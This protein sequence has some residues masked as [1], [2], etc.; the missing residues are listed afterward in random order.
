MQ[1]LSSSDCPHYTCPADEDKCYRV[2]FTYSN[3]ELAGFIALFVTCCI[4]SAGGIGAASLTLSVYTILL[5]FLPPDA[6]HLSRITTLATALAST[7]TLAIKNFKNLLSH[8]G[9]NSE[10]KSIKRHFDFRLAA[11]MI[12]L[13]LAGAELGLIFNEFFCQF[14]IDSLLIILVGFSFNVVKKR[15]QEKRNPDEEIS[16][17]RAVQLEDQ[18][19]LQVKGSEVGF[20]YISGS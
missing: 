14:I 16:E 10:E 5:G 6:V 1:C 19:N 2:D 7:A 18:K 15:S 12:P 4:A 17:K 9:V 8:S 13:H 20:F 11:M 3:F